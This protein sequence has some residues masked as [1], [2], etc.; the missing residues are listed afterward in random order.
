V[1]VGRYDAGVGGSFSER[2][3]L[4]GICATKDV[5]GYGFSALSRKFKTILQAEIEVMPI[6]TENRS[7]RFWLGS[8][9]AKNIILAKFA[10]AQTA[11]NRIWSRSSTAMMFD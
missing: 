5:T 8:V 10:A 2:V 11:K 7:A 1:K 9:T 6:A 3:G 4:K